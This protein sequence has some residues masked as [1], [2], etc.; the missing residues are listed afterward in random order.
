[1]ARRTKEDALATRDSILDAAELLFIDQGV[2]KTTLQHIAA[3]A[4]V[5]RGAVYWHF[6]DKAAL[7]NALMERA[8]LPVEAAMR[9]LDTTDPLDPL[10]DLH[11]YAVCVFRLTTDDAR[12]R[13]AFEIVTLK[14]EFVSELDAMRVRRREHMDLW[15]ERATSRVKIAERRGQLKAGVDAAAVALGLWVLIEGLIRNWLM[16][17]RFDLVAMGA[18]IVDTHLAALRV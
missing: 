5:T 14:T 15:T 10:H 7:A 18:R 4:G 2:S 1:M 12:A 9:T 11:E 17:P 13:R 6:L 3:A 8:K 16:D